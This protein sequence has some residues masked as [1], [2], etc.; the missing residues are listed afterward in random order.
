M[1][2]N[3]SIS[4]SRHIGESFC[5]NSNSFPRN[6]VLPQ[7]FFFKFLYNLK[8]GH[9]HGQNCHKQNNDYVELRYFVFIVV[10]LFFKV[11]FRKQKKKLR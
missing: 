10:Y 4:L 7:H 1:T 6:W 11:Y 3:K 2:K 8:H 5:H 9:Q